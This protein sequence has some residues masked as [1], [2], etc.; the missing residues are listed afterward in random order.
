MH[1]LRLS[2]SNIRWHQTSKCDKYAKKKLDGYK[3]LFLTF[4]FFQYPLKKKKS[5]IKYDSLLGMLVVVCRSSMWLQTDYLRKYW[6][7]CHENLVYGPRRLTLRTSA[8]VKTYQ[9]FS[10]DFILCLFSLTQFDITVTQTLTAYKVLTLMTQ[11]QI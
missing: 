10:K 3:I 7:H 1:L 5:H 9:L 2:L 6:M 8:T 4:H 11:Q